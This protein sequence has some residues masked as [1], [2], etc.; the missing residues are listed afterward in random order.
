MIVASRLQVSYVTFERQYKI[1]MIMLIK[2][3]TY[4]IMPN[5]LITDPLAKNQNMVPVVSANKFVL[6][7]QM[8]ML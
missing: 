8:R 3:T 5:T 2:L 1:R 4:P 7:I 6:V